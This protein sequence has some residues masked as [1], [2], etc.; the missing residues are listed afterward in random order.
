MNAAAKRRD[1]Q[2]VRAAVYAR[3]STDE[4]A[5]EGT[6]IGVQ[7]ERCQKAVADRE[8]AP[9]GTFVDEGVSGSRDSR[10]A[11]DELMEACRAG[12]VDAVVVA[13][14]DRFT[15]STAHLFPALK[16]LESLG[17]VFVSLKEGFDLSTISGRAQLGMMGVFAEM[18][19]ETIA[20]RGASGQ[21]ARVAAGLWP[22]GQAPWGIAV[23]PNPDGSGKV[24]VIDEDE[25]AV[26]RLAARLLV[27]DGMT[28]GQVA[29]RLNAL[30]HRPR[31]AARFTHYSVRRCMEN[32][33]LNGVYEWG[34]DRSRHG[35][36]GSSGKYGEAVPVAMPKVLDDEVFAA[37]QAAL[38][39]KRLGPRAVNRVYPIS[40]GVLWS[41]CGRPMHGAWR[42]DRGLRQYWCPDGKRTPA[43]PERCACPRINAD[44]VEWA[45]WEQVVG[46]L[47]DPDRLRALAAE[48][49]EMGHD[50]PDGTRQLAD[51]ERRLRAVEAKLDAAVE[52]KLGAAPAEAAAVAR[53]VQRLS[54]ES[55]ELHDLQGSILGVLGEAQARTEA[56]DQLAQLASRGRRALDDMSPTDKAAVMRLMEL[57]VEV[58]MEP[59][60]KA[61]R[62][63]MSGRVPHAELVDSIC[64][65]GGQVSH[66]SSR[67][68]A[69][70]RR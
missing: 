10:P 66:G 29:D 63:R 31:K 61:W 59:D 51:V 7:V 38:D 6:S 14:L 18:E 23:A 46:V 62:L 19:R 49:L 70:R 4:Q 34:K 37:V 55:Q 24:A 27:E 56:A 28:T 16:E 33:N 13:K 17:V 54:R 20:E 11:L 50:D 60:G 5:R 41:P 52:A 47:A 57:R 8:W 40:N 67:L 2:A 12:K 30:G 39:G 36:V 48:R 65:G 22:G 43:K 15:R 68:G 45:V 58:V 53:V 9:A 69:P 64:N 1:R 25:A 3:V 35:V 26:I 21:R 42:A 32:P 44:D